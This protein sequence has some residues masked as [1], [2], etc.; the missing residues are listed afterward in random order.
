MMARILEEKIFEKAR[1]A[2]KEFLE[3]RFDNIEEPPSREF[4]DAALPVFEIAKSLKK[5]PA[6]IAKT[7]A[8][9]ISE[10][11]HAE[12]KKVEAAGGF[13]NFTFAPDF[14]FNALFSSIKEQGDNYGSNISC[15]GQRV[16]IEF[17]GLNTHKEVHVG[18][19]RNI[20]IGDSMVRLYRASG[21]FTIAADYTNDFGLH[22]AICLWA[23]QKFHKGYAPP[24]SEKGRWLGDV[25]AEGVRAIEENPEF[26]KAVDAVLNALEDRKSD[27]IEIFLETRNWSLERFHEIYSELGV[28]FDVSFYESDI[29]DE[30]K[31]IVGELLER[32]VAKKSEGAV[33]VDLSEYGLDVLLVL[34]SDG[35]GIYATSDLAL[36]HEKFRRFEID[37]S[38]YITDV[39]QS[40]YFKQLFKTLELAGFRK[41][42]EHIGYEFVRLPEGAISSRRGRVVIYED[43]K[44]EIFSKAEYETKKRHPDWSDEK[45]KNTAQAIAFG[46]M[47][48]DLLKHDPGKVVI[49]DISKAVSFDGFT[50]PYVQYTY[51][52]IMSMF[53]KNAM[54]SKHTAGFG[55]IID[56]E[57][58]KEEKERLLAVSL[59]NFPRV[60]ESAKAAHN[61]SYICRYLFDLAKE[62]SGFYESCPVLSSEENL[63]DAR[64]TLCGATGMV[65]KKGLNLLGISAIDEM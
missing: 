11:N 12:F 46:A 55:G 5:S 39:R 57:A 50:A 58:L 25:Y 20:F 21:C 65:L 40:F 45:I 62:F 38:I 18:H 33:I 48:F 60:I 47:R 26:K 61:S 9:T 13:I 6:Q 29:K 30:G 34:K 31:E 56:A 51:A 41:K 36:A 44:K 52:R 7:L 3:I 53:R 32:G 28:R 23:L 2:S 4:G 15:E 19:L 42:M 37:K 27:W 64:L 17:S 22:V 59:F 43:F 54:L 1:D 63:R 49:F 35:T 10:K 8:Q 14:V 24:E 16:M